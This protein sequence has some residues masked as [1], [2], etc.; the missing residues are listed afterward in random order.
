MEEAF[1]R[2]LEYRSLGSPAKL[3]KVR[4]AVIDMI[5]LRRFASEHGFTYDE[6]LKRFK[7]GE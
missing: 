1:R 7:Q 4:S 3:G 6:K 2:E 5:Q